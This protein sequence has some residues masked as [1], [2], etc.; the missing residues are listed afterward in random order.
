MLQ[1]E[2]KIL[3]LIHNASQHARGIPKLISS[4]A[5]VVEGCTHTFM[6]MQRLGSDLHALSTQGII[7]RDNFVQ[8]RS[9]EML[10]L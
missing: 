6:V 8:V 1:D 10:H 4:G 7:A 9:H 2:K 5:V 3:E